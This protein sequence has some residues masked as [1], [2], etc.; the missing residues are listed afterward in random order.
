MSEEMFLYQIK[1]NKNKFPEECAALERAKEG[2]GIA[3]YLRKLIQEDLKK[4]GQVTSIERPSPIP[5]VTKVPPS[6]EMTNT[7]VDLPDDN[8]GFM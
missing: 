5:T 1:W 4:N 3:W 7:N 6:K 2:N 8:G